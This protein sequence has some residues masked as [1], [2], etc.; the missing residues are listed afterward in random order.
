[1]RED[2]SLKVQ[3]AAGGSI[4]ATELQ[5]LD[6]FLVPPVLFEENET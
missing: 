4:L 1:M 3:S 2:D 5:A 6:G